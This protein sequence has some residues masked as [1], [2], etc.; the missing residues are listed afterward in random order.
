MASKNIV[1]DPEKRQASEESAAETL[2]KVRIFGKVR[3]PEMSKTA[4]LRVV[5][6][7]TP[8]GIFGNVP[9][10][11]PK[12]KDRRPREHLTEAEVTRL[13]VAAGKRGRHRHRDKTMIMMAFRHGLRAAELV[14]LKWEDFNLDEALMSVHRDKNGRNTEHP[15]CGEE[16]RDLRRLKRN[17]P[18][19]SRFLFMSERGAPL[20]PRA[21]HVIVVAAGVLCQLSF[22]VHPHMLRHAAGYKLVTDQQPIRE[23][24]RYL[25]HRDVRSTEVYTEAAPGRFNE[26]FR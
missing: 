18:E 20:T 10:R 12:N 16:L 25:G 24:Q 14:N 15:I 19:G 23:I 21:F 5:V 6:D 9:P 1:P 13:A 7:N 2:P 11:K 3:D 17:Q 8:T 22:P 4:C 26:F